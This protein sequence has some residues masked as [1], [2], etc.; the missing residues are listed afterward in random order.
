MI[1]AT[2]SVLPVEL[3]L[4]PQTVRILHLPFLNATKPFPR[5]LLRLEVGGGVREIEK[6]RWG[7]LHRDA[8]EGYCRS[9]CAP[10]L[11]AAA[12]AAAGD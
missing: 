4:T 6:R 9:L 2:T 10:F 3:N 7:S 5:F 11:E 1:K 12:A 8:P